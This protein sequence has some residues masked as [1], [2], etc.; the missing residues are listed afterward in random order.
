MALFQRLNRDDGM[1]VVIITHD[2]SIAERCQ[3]RLELQD[4]LLI[5]DIGAFENAA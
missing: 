2:P 3:R 4:G 1:T 5:A